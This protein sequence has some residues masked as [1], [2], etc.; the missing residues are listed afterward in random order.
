V[1]HGC[2]FKRSSNS[3]VSKFPGLSQLLG[4]WQVAFADIAASEQEIEDRQKHVVA[5]VGNVVMARVIGAGEVQSGR[6]P[7]VH[8]N[9][10]V[11]FLAQDQLHRPT[12]EDTAENPLL[13]EQKTD[14]EGWDSVDHE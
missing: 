2:P 8:V 10:P 6:K 9:P 4:L 1:G 13:A 7:A 3:R 14:E 5:A 11:D 12:D